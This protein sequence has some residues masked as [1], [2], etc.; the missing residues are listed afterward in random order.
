[1]W[2]I[3]GVYQIFLDQN[4]FQTQIFFGPKFFSDS[5][6]LDPKFFADINFFFRPKNFSGPKNLFRPQNLFGPNIFFRPNFFFR[7]KTFQTQHFIGPKMNFNENDL[8]GNKTGLL[9]LRLSKLPSSKIL[10]KLEFDTK[11]QV[12]MFFLLLWHG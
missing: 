8:W 6:F 12:L 10:L 5:N 1:M 7:P 11:D 3:G 2:H 4:F 9:N